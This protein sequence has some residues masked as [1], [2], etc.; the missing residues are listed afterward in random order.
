MTRGTL[1]R[2]AGWGVG[3]AALAVLPVVLPI[4]HQFVLSLALVNAIAAMG[5]NL[6]MGYAGQVS[7]GH[8]GFVAIGAYTTAVLMAR[9]S[10]PF[11]VTVP[12]GGAMAAIFGFLIGLPALRLSHLYIGMVTFGFGQAI[13]FIALN[14]VALTNG[15]NGI[16]V[17]PVTVGAFAFS[18]DTFYYVIAAVFLVL[19]WI[20]HNLVRSRVGRCFLAIRESE[21]A[22]EAMGVNL[23]RYKTMAFAVGAAYGGFAGC[24][25]AGLS[26]F[27]NPDAFVFLVSVLYL[28]MN[29]VGGMG[30]LAGPLLGAAIFTVM[31]EFLRAFAE[32]KEFLSGALLLTFLVF[33]PRGL[34]GILGR[35]LGRLRWRA[36]RAGPLPAASSVTDEA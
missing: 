2:A 11:W 34:V 18:P 25:Y 8:A 30:T 1:G 33:F 4:Y 6:S 24:L 32:Y 23:V 19:F 16:A 28:T 10:V 35:A 5:V 27:V 15:P 36:A 26:Q 31:P 7:I 22:A 29:V 13:N 17:P 20:A 3:V 21:T 9:L 12:L 14:W